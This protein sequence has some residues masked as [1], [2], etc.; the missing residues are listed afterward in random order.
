ML[1]DP[2]ADMFVRIK[3]AQYARL[4]SV[5]VPHS[6]VKQDIAKILEARRFIA[7]I[8]RRGKKNKRGLELKLVY[9]PSGAG[10]IR[11]LKRISKPSRRVYKGYKELHPSARGNGLYI[12]STPAG[13]LDD[14]KAR[15]MKVGG[16]VLGEIY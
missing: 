3:N 14:K 7:E 13:I 10:R 4:D 1:S 11:D 15:E 2:I 9:E 16:E 6:R 5:V 12:I 8:A